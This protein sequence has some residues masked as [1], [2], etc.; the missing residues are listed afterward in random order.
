LFFNLF[1]CLF[2][3]C[4][5]FFF[6]FFYNWAQ[7][8]SEKVSKTLKT[9]TYPNAQTNIVAVGANNPIIVKW[10]YWL[11]DSILKNELTKTESWNMMEFLT[12][13]PSRLIHR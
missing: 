5:F 1:V 4:F 7:K 2:V 3:C 8:F 10:S 11:Y 9:V 13:I 6:F 12:Y